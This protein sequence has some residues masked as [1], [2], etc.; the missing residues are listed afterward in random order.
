MM[1]QNKQHRR[2]Q[3]SILK[4]HQTTSK[5]ALPNKDILSKYLLRH[6]A[7]TFILI[8]CVKSIHSA[9]KPTKSFAVPSSAN[10][11]ISVLC[12]KKE[13]FRTFSS[14][15]V[16]RAAS[17]A[18]Q[19]SRAGAAS[20]TSHKVLISAGLTTPTAFVRLALLTLLTLLSQ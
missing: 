20:H 9:S 10:I 4:Q 15:F 11:H 6:A 5:H 14:H 19:N 1:E 3:T 13:E 7:V 8:H 17:S 16:H 12:I 2:D 18:A